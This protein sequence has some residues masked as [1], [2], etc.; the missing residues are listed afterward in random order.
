MGRSGRLGRPEEREQPCEV[1]LARLA[2]V[3]ADL[4]RLGELDLL[5]A[6]FAVPARGLLSEALGELAVSVGLAV[7][8]LRYAVL[9]VGRVLRHQGLVADRAAFEELRLHHGQ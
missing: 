1:F 9:A 7:P 8:H 4:E 6:L 5:R 3:L 2:A